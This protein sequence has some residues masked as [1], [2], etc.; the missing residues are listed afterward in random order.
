MGRAA[1]G[2]L[3]ER[4]TSERDF[5][6]RNRILELLGVA[7][8][9][10]EATLVAPRPASPSVEHG[11]FEH[12]SVVA[13]ELSDRERAVLM[14]LGVMRERWTTLPLPVIE[15]VRLY[16]MALR[17]TRWVYWSVAVLL[18]MDVG[19]ISNVH[20]RSMSGIEALSLVGSQIVAAVLCLVTF[21]VWRRRSNQLTSP[22]SRR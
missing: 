5:K 7:R 8:E 21:T 18:L 16:V 19:T 22:S 3:D 4:L 11:S 6:V 1:R 12:G 14:S 17:N 9:T 2:A 20:D 10:P 13:F 15:R